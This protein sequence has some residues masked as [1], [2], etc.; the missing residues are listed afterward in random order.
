MAEG[1]THTL[2]QRIRRLR[3]ER[4]WSQAQ[5]AKKIETHPKQISGYERGVHVPSTEMLIRIATVFGVSLDYLAFDDRDEARRVDL[6]DIELIE[7]LEALDKL[8]AKDRETIKAVIDSFILKNEFQRLV[9][10]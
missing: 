7:R 1:V 2:S 4:N 5:L 8:S 10:R 3:Q 6:A 9:A